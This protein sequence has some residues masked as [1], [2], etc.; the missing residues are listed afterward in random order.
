MMYV[1]R[2]TYYISIYIVHHGGARLYM[3][4]EIVPI[5]P[6]LLG[7]LLFFFG[8]AVIFLPIT[9]KHV[10]RKTQSA[11]VKIQQHNILQYCSV[12]SKYI[13]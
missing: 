3:C 11:A 5:N 7:M 10:F 1:V 13:I 2:R 9:T 4:I 8:A 12:I 6:D